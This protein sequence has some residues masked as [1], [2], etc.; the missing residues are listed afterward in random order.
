[1]DTILNHNKNGFKNF[2]S[3]E[4]FELELNFQNGQRKRLKSPITFWGLV[5][6]ELL[7]HQ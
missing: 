3:L 4:S 6:T 5:I 2:R 7:K 1:M